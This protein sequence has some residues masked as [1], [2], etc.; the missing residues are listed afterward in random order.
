LSEAGSQNKTPFRNRLGGLVNES[1]TES[2]S[3]EL[4]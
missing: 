2:Y 1:L 4:A 3:N